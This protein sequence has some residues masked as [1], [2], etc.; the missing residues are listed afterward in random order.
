MCIKQ[1]GTYA[2]IY[3]APFYLQLQSEKETKI[4]AKRHGVETYFPEVLPH[5]SLHALLQQMREIM[6][7]GLQC[8]T[9]LMSSQS[10]SFSVLNEDD[11]LGG[12]SGD[13]VNK[14]YFILTKE[15]SFICDSAE[16]S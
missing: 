10:K 15:R 4:R 14:S 16:L 11:T 7:E 3:V 9:A 6:K 12:K 5:V 8:C 2:V 13:H 1:L